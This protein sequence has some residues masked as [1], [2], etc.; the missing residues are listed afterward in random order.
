METAFLL[1]SGLLLLSHSIYFLRPYIL[2]KKGFRPQKVD[3]VVRKSA[4]VLLLPTVIFGTIVLSSIISTLFIWL[5]IILIVFSQF[6]RSW[7][8]KN[9]YV[10]P[11]T[12]FGLIFLITLLAIKELLWL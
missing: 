8:K 4:T 7:F 5:P 9:P 6:K 1:L 2:R 10:L 12:N 3:H 11:I